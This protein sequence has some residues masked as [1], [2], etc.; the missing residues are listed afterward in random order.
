MGSFVH[1]ITVKTKN[2]KDLQKVV[3][4]THESAYVG[5][6]V[7][8]WIPV[9][10]EIY[11]EFDFSEKASEKLQTVVLVGST[12]DSDDLYFQIYDKGKKAFEYDYAPTFSKDIGVIRIGGIDTLNKYTLQK[13]DE[14]DI[15]DILTAE[16]GKNDKYVF[17][18]ERYFDILEILDIPKGLARGLTSF[19]YN[20]IE[21]ASSQKELEE[22]I[23]KDLPNLTKYT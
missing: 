6:P 1:S 17:V 9:F 13:K 10:P 22:S 2:K 20:Y 11:G 14:K 15:K 16:A 7:D 3:D 12:H 21:D 23:K 18:E 5:D 8:N 4:E 19:A